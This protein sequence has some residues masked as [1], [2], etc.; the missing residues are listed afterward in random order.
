MLALQS[1]TNLGSRVMRYTFD[2]IEGASLNSTVA[3]NSELRDQGKSDLPAGDD[4]RE[5]HGR[6]RSGVLLALSLLWILNWVSVLPQITDPR[7]T[8][9]QDFS[10]FYTG[11]KIV[12]SGLSSHLYDLSVQAR[13]Q[14]APYRSQPLPFDHPAYELLLFLPFAALSF[15]GAY[16]LW[17]AINVVMVLLAALLLSPHLPNFPRP[18]APWI[19]AAAMAAFPLIWSICQ[20]QDSILLLLLFVLAYLN[21]KAGK[22]PVAGFIL[23][24]G[25]FKFTLVVPFLVPFLFRRRWRFLAGFLAGSALVGGISVLMTGITGS[26]QYIQLLSLL[27]AHP[28]VGYINL[29]LMPNVR[30]FL[31]TLL[32]GHGVHRRE[33]DIFSGIV[34]V[35]L[36]IVPLLTYC[37]REQAERFELWFGLNLTI[38]V[39]VSP[40]LYWH[41]LTILLLPLLLAS[42]VLLKRGIRMDFTLAAAIAWTFLYACAWPVWPV[43][44]PAL[45][46]VSPSIF[47]VPLC[48][49]ALWLAIRIRSHSPG[50]ATE[51]VPGIA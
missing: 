1:L 15:S 42:N 40:H 44:L 14:T 3:T 46:V 26:R 5:K 17:T 11:S 24:A 33:F 32:A 20:G 43:Y 48:G 29:F 34:S 8:G 51:T 31:L 45:K 21:L 36:L 19:F 7:H 2:A 28:S 35:L 16:W 37:G 18:A 41:D 50:R 4:A 30:G 23:A 6:V 9:T 27:T 49:F 47:F 22:D 25:L 38:A 10:I 13:Y 12:L 39:V